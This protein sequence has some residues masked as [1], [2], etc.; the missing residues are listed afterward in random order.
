VDRRTSLDV[1]RRK[2]SHHCPCRELNPGRPARSL[3]SIPTELPRFL[4]TCSNFINWK[5]TEM[6]DRGVEDEFLG[7]LITAKI[8]DD[9]HI[10]G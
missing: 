2:T 3:V 9:K 7:E 8:E 4:V 5:I 10:K 6:E 1:V